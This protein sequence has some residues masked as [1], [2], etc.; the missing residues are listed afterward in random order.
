MC[1]QTKQ[2]KTRQKK[3]QRKAATNEHQKIKIESKPTS[4]DIGGEE[5]EEEGQTQTNTATKKHSSL[6]FPV[7][8]K[9][10]TKEIT[11]YEC[12]SGGGGGGGAMRETD[13]NR[14]RAIQVWWVEEG[15]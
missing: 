7:L 15:Q 9:A 3:Q 5:S 14:E 6:S 12:G 2:N 1:N 8:K 13:D 11:H 4:D 10:C